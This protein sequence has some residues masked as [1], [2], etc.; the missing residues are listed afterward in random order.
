VQVQLSTALASLDTSKVNL[1]ESTELTSS[2]KVENTGRVRSEKG[3]EG[4]CR[5]VE[6]EKGGL[7]DGSMGVKA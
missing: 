7:G 2:L 4:G 6:V 5:C 1:D 3:R